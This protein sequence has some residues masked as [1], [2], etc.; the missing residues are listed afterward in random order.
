MVIPPRP[1]WGVNCLYYDTTLPS[2]RQVTSSI[3]RDVNTREIHGVVWSWNGTD[4]T[5][6]ET[7]I[8]MRVKLR[9]RNRISVKKLGFFS[10][11]SFHD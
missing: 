2:L 3:D 10:N 6:T 11:P 9:F 4:N 7:D 1:R 8:L 5:G